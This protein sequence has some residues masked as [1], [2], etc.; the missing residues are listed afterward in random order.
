MVLV[1]KARV[2]RGVERRII[3]FDRFKL[4][5]SATDDAMISALNKSQA[6]IHFNLD[7]TII[8]ANDNFLKVM[9]YSLAEIQG[10]H[11]SMFV[12]PGFETTQEYKDFWTQLRSG[13]FQMA[14]YKRLGKGGKEV[15]IL[16]SYNPVQDAAG[17]PVKVV[18]FATDITD[19]KRQNAEFQGQIDALNRSQAIIHFE[20]DGTILEANDNFLN[21]M[22]YRLDEIQGK[23]HSMFVAP[24]QRD[25][26]EY[27]T[28]WKELGQGEFKA[29]EYMRISKGG[30]E[31]WIQAAYNPIKDPSGKVY[32]VVKF[33][34]DIT[35]RMLRAAE[36]EG[37]VAAINEAQAVIHFELDGT[38]TYANENFL[39]AMGYSLA[40][41]QG[42]HHSMFVEP[43][44]EK[45]E[46]YLSFW[47]SLRKGNFQSGEY[48]RL[49]KGGKEVWIQASYNPI[50]DPKGKPFKVIK[51]ATDRTAQ[52]Q[53]RA[54]RERVG[55]QVDSSL[56]EI[57]SSANDVES[58]A[59]S[60]AAASKQSA[61][62]VQTVAAATEEFSASV[63]EV[64]QSMANSQKSVSDALDE[65][66]AASSSTRQMAES[67][68]AMNSI[69]EIIQQIA[70]QINLLS[71]NAT[72]ESARAGEAG[73]GFAVV[74]SEVKNLAGQVASATTTISEQIDGIQG[75]SDDVVSRL[76]AIQRQVEAVHSSV[77]GVAGAVEEQ[78]A[79]TH[80]ISA[81]IQQASQAVD[82]IEEALRGIVASAGKAAELSSE[83]IEL[84]RTLR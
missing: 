69:V 46:E 53:M 21:A 9:G 66:N 6:V 68:G 84:Y 76:S 79:T 49:G 52:V 67:A 8:S 35:D 39:G 54:E 38:I 50:L 73:K 20:P 83:G 2:P 19:A 17:N 63:N 64:A 75:I 65:V 1:T 34:T 23:H 58:R 36:H 16:A 74:A 30:R 82:S 18:K 5:T 37:Q 15:W 32:K 70:S 72:I 43:G 59:A 44:F 28:F 45:S 7:G 81:S 25:S 22:G 78:N 11:H 60:A 3:L 27:K 61:S 33:A 13:K 56:R 71:L 47:E 24:D 10:K 48:K 40:E 12:E 31:V 26:Q 51:F 29:A 41:I 77:T 80:E 42:K 4:R 57:Q 14:E 55:T 62:T